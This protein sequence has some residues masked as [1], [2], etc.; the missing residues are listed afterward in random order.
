MS[1]K[2]RTFYGPLALE[3]LIYGAFVAAYLLLV[4][5]FLEGPLKGLFDRS[6]TSYAAVAL[7]LVVGQGVV[8][9]ALTALLVRWLRPR[10]G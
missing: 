10:R 5:H 9:D 3:L 4:L 1:D 7:A 8:L 2:V 6:R